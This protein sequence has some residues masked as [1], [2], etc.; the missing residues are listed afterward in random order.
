MIEARRAGDLLEATPMDRPE[1]VEPDPK[2]GRVWVMLTNNSRRKS[3]KVNPANPRAKNVSGHIIE[4]TEPNGDFTST[5]S[6]WDII[7]RCGDPKDRSTTWN[8]NTSENGWFGSP[9]NCALDV[10]GRLW[11]ATDGNDRTG[12]ADGL[13]ALDTDGS[14][15]GTGKAFFRVPIGAELCGPRF[16]DDGETLFLAVQHPGDG[17]DASFENPTTRWPDFKDNMP[18]RP[19][20]M[21][22]RNIN[23]KIVGSG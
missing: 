14:A 16:T 3:G 18:P 19:A 17:N 12:A 6:E 10:N 4:I 8:P 1:D 2:T 13:W 7:V 22:I 5:V 21:A 23:G 15:R 20:V 9:D 11:I